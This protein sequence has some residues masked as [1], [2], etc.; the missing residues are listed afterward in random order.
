MRLE[1]EPRARRS[2]AL[3]LLAPIIAFAAALCIGAVMILA[4]GKSPAQAFSV[5]FVEPLT[6]EWS[7]E[8]I[9]KKAAPLILI[10]IGLSFCFRSNIWNIGAEGQLVVGGALGG[11]VGLLTLGQPDG[12][13]V[14][15]LP[16]MMLTG[17]LGG[18]AYALIP[19]LLRVRFGVSEI[20][21]SLM[22]VYVAELWLDYMVR[23]P[24]RARGAFNMPVPA[25]LDPAAVLPPITA[26]GLHAGVL[27]APVAVVAAM[28]LLRTL[29][30]FQTRLVGDAARA[31]HHFIGHLSKYASLSSLSGVAI[32]LSVIRPWPSLTASNMWKSWIG[33]WLVL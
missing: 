29:F 10:A 33:N 20:L 3:D 12:A 16:A 25:P 17:A 15:V 11:Y 14:W 23:G 13:I 7:R 9:L 24:W 8:A 22:L 28:A 31:A 32:V 2:P 30:G 26:E 5:Y 6:Q 27:F 18:L 1:L 21:T 4:L 19:A